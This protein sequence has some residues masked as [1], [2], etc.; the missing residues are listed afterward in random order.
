MRLLNTVFLVDHTTNVRQRAGSLVVS[1]DSGKQR[2]PLEGID[3][4]VILGGASMT[5]DAITACVERGVRVSCHQRTGR[6]RWT[7]APPTSGNV[8]LRLAQYRAAETA[9]LRLELCRTFVAAKL[10]SSRRIVRRW[11]R[12]SSGLLRQQLALRADRIDASI[13]ALQQAHTDDQV[14][15]IEGDAA[16]AF[17]ACVG[18]VL[19]D[20][21]FSFLVRSRRPPRDPVNAVLGFSY[22]LATTELVGALDGVGLDPQIGFLHRPRPGRPALALDLLEELRPLIDRFVVGLVRRNQLGESDFVQTPG[23]ATYLS[24]EGR[25]R[26]LAL[27][28][29]HKTSQLR[30]HFVSRDIER[31]A[32]PQLQATLLAR[33]LRGDLAVYPPFVIAE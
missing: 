9:P 16:R 31:W 7:A 28:E 12:D 3:H 6:L 30:H 18:A 27:W 19:A 10:Q 17:F 5:L 29:E 20:S 32:L 23:G 25:R 8:Q 22:A 13:G 24:D 11:S 2:I 33:H 21:G 14:R 26:F 4:V 1:G 15:G